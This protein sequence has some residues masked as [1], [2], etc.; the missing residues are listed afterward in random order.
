MRVL[1]VEDDDATRFA[2]SDYLKKAGIDW[3]SIPT[4]A[5]AMVYT[6]P[7]HE[8]DAITIDLTLPDMDGHDLIRDIRK[9]GIM[10]PILVLTED[11]SV[12]SKVKAL[13]LGADDYVT[14]PFHKDELVAR[15]RTIVRGRKFGQKQ[16]LEAAVKLSRAS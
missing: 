11:A 15:L 7:V 12:E 5:G 16:A 2:I 1:I 3:A 13:D 14:K 4:A 9:K 6:R 8:F 10:T